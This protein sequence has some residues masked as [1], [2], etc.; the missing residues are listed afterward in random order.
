MLGEGIGWIDAA[1]RFEQTAPPAV[2]RQVLHAA[3]TLAYRRA[4]YAAARAFHERALELARGLEDRVA[5]ALSLNNLGI[6][7]VDVG[8]DAAAKAFYERSLALRRVLG[9]PHSLGSVLNNLADVAYR[10][11]DLDTAAARYAES[12]EQY[13][14]EGDTWSEASVLSNLGGLDVDRGE[15]K[16]RAGGSNKA[17][18]YGAASAT[19][20]CTPSWAWGTSP[21]P[22][23]T[24]PRPRRA[25]WRA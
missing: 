20:V 11:G 2:V 4:D 1:L 14:A 17:S 18:R 15:L 7:A 21:S 24:M 9:N 19:Q 23:A 12:L 13:R 3:G 5:T 6:V 25:S 10:L 8:D 22:K 16:R